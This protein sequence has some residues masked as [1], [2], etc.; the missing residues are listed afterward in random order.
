MTDLEIIHKHHISARHRAAVELKIVHRLLSDAE[1]AYGDCCVQIQEDELHT[2]LTHQEAID[3]LFDL[4]EA[5]VLFTK[6]GEEIEGWVKLIFGNGYDVIS[7]YS[8]VL[9]DLMAPVNKFAD[10]MQED[11]E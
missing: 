7:D 8:T 2:G 4:D 5:D 6:D 3:L 11:G 1:K 9:E 10:K